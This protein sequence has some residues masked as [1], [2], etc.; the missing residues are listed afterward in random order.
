MNE[1][2]HLKPGLASLQEELNG[3]RTC[4]WHSDPNCI[5]NPTTGKLLP[6]LANVLIALRSD[7]ELKDKINYDE[8]QRAPVW[9]RQRPATD[10]DITKVQEYLQHAGISRISKDTVHQAVDCYAREHGYHPVR[11]YLNA[12]SWDGVARL[13]NWLSTYLGCEPTPYVSGIGRMFLISMVAR[14]YVPGCKVD[15]MPILEGP[16]GILKSTACRILG[17]QWFSDS[18][19]EVTAGKDVA[20]HLR[21]KWL[22][23]VSEMHAMNKA[24]TTLL[25]AFLT[26]DIERYRPSYG[27][28]EVIEPRQ[29]VFVGTTN[30]DSYLRDETGG[31]RFWPAKC[32]DIDVNQLKLDRDQLFAETVTRYRKG[33]HWWPDRE[34]ERMHIMPQQAARYEGDAWTDPVMNNLRTLTRTTIREIATNALGLDIRHLGMPEQKRI[35]AI[36]IGLGWVPQRNK[37]DRWWEKP[38]EMGG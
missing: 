15:H 33:E 12:L 1:I 22:L 16:Q 23:E 9:E 26:R 14:I 11:D 8:M 34:F 35:A 25:K 27:R 2:I 29:C 7:P 18:L 38:A 5:K 17:D 32:G 28:L 30:K 24:E 10:A 21:G 20:Q 37:H 13:E 19:P 6:V 4:A 3:L 31:R 36:L